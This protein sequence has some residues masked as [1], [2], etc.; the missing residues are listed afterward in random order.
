MWTINLKP[1][2][3]YHNAYEERIKI[4]KQNRN[5]CGIYLWTNTITGKSYAG[6]SVN[7]SRRIRDYFY[8]SYLI[9]ELE[10]NNSLIY[11]SL[12]KHNY[13]GFRL[14]ILEYCEKILL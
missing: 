2:Y 8:K 13:K 10:K 6:S 3:S 14:D 9:R 11:K 5:K 12:L 4:F 1:I 7:L